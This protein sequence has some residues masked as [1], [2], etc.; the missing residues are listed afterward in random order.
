[1]AVP[2]WRS[3]AELEVFGEQVSPENQCHMLIE[4][5]EWTAVP[6]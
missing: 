2:R 6:R 4:A 5:G 3:Q 1:M